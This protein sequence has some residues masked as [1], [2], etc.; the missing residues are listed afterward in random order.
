M[1][2]F[3]AVIKDYSNAHVPCSSVFITGSKQLLHTGNSGDADLRPK[4]NHS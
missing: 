4:V 2:L 3:Q 1:Y